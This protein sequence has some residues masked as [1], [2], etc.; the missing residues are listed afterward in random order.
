MNVI[1]KSDQ[2]VKSYF[3]DG[4]LRIGAAHAVEPTSSS[5]ETTWSQFSSSL[6]RFFRR[7]FYVFAVF[8]PLAIMLGV[9]YIVLATPIYTAKV[10]MVIDTRKG[11]LFQT[12]ATNETAVDATNAVLTEIE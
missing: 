2:R 10:V 6:S 4:K 12:S 3:Q 7:Q 8:V 5:D 9:A 11:Q 1:E